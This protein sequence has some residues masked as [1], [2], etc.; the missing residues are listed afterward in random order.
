MILHPTSTHLWLYVDMLYF[1]LGLQLKGIFIIDE[2]E[3]LLHLIDNCMVWNKEITKG[4][5][6]HN[7]LESKVMSSSC[8]LKSRSSKPRQIQFTMV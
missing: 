5:P 4:N 1:I 7:F 8:F 2:S 3:F 6:D